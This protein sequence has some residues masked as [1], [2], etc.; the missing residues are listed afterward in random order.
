[1]S[2]VSVL[3]SEMASVSIVCD[4]A[5]SW[6]G[7]VCRRQMLHSEHASR[8]FAE[9]YP[10]LCALPRPTRWQR[11][12]GQRND[13]F[14]LHLNKTRRTASCIVNSAAPGVYPLFAASLIY[15]LPFYTMVDNLEQSLSFA[16]VPLSR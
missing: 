8:V 16:F 3:R 5:T 15:V 9:D 6:R 14:S 2:A 13:R 12:F 11:R 4:L 10:L 7:T 1:M